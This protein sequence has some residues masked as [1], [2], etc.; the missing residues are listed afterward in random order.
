MR[1]IS[2]S[3]AAA[4]VPAVVSAQR[5]TLGPGLT[6]IVDAGEGVGRT[7]LQQGY[8]KGM[9]LTLLVPV[10]SRFTSV[11]VSGRGYWLS[12]SSSCADGFPAPDGTYLQEDRVNLLSQN[13]VSTDLRVAVQLGDQI[14]VSL[15]LGGGGAWHQ[16]HDLP[17]IVAGTTVTVADNQYLRVELGAEYQ[18]LR[19]TSDQFLR[20]FQNFEL[21]QEEFLGQVHRWSHAVIFGG[22]LGFKL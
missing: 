18:W 16:G 8:N 22:T 1:F 19:V 11:Q 21:T 5:P 14:P 2:L 3:L 10:F 20:T 13:F 4:L 7:C 17:Y 12:Q 15:A 6:W 9:G